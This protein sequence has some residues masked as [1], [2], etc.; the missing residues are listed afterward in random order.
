[1]DADVPFDVGGEYRHVSHLL[2]H[3]VINKS[4][5]DKKPRQQAHTYN[6]EKC[7]KGYSSSTISCGI[8]FLFL[9]FRCDPLSSCQTSERSS[10][11][12]SYAGWSE[13]SGGAGRF[14]VA[15]RLFR[16]RSTIAAR[17]SKITIAALTPIPAFASALK[18]LFVVA[19]EVSDEVGN[20]V[21]VMVVGILVLEGEAVGEVLGLEEELV[22]GRPC[23][24]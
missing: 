19:S 3:R 9:E 18:L 14:V 21:A 4:Y 10:S 13:Y 2:R 15:L 11:L 7:T 24:W 6:P 22:A 20:E 17:T 12:L 8:G 23:W 5:S 1:M 16:N